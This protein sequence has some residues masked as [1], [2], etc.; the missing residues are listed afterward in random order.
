MAMTSR[1]S[2][3]LP[4]PSKG[5]GFLLPAAEARR[6]TNSA[7][8][9]QG[10][11]EAFPR[12]KMA[13]TAIRT[14]RMLP[15]LLW[16]QLCPTVPPSNQRAPPPNQ[17]SARGKQR[18]GPSRVYRPDPPAAIRMEQMLPPRSAWTALPWECRADPAPS[19]ADFPAPPAYPYPNPNPHARTVPPP[20]S[21]TLRGV[22]PR[23]PG[24]VP[25]AMVPAI[26]RA[27]PDHRPSVAAAVLVA[28]VAAVAATAAIAAV[29]QIN[30]RQWQWQR[31][32]RQR[33]G[34]RAAAVAAA[35]V[36]A[37]V[38]MTAMPTRRVWRW[39]MMEER[40]LSIPGNGGTRKKTRGPREC[41]GGRRQTLATR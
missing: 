20:S 30:R 1:P 26:V 4:P 15:H 23:R 21:R 35:A 40:Q 10:A 41:A 2:S 32:R 9:P 25:A 6:P 17:R 37:V 19:C 27:S 24:V 33:G 39:T 7:P 29:L 3:L 5:I 14:R 31:R 34:K 38:S 12:R 16:E 18:Q 22:H 8:V 13:V 36:A 11:N 28:A